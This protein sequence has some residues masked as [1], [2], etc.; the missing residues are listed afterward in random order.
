MMLKIKMM[1]Y[2]GLY[3]ILK[4]KKYTK[5]DVKNIKTVINIMVYKNTTYKQNHQKW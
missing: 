1:N 4:T 3:K 2:D 5:N